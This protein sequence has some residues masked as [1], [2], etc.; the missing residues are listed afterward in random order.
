M[1]L[2]CGHGNIAAQNPTLRPYFQSA[3]MFTKLSAGPCALARRTLASATSTK[4][5]GSWSISSLR[6]PRGSLVSSNS[7]TTQRSSVQSR[8]TTT[9]SA[10]TDGDMASSPGARL[11][12]L[13]WDHTFVRELPAD[14][15]TR[16]TVRQVEGALFSR[17]SPTPPTGVPYLI[18]YSEKVA[19][20]IGLNPSECLRPEFPLLM[21]GAAPLPG[22][23]PYAACYGGHQFGSWAGQLGD[24]R[25][26]TLGELLNRH[27]P[28]D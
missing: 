24:G 6:G 18:A 19:R 11:E 8:S 5:L 28:P 16:N 25:A 3:Q 21:S 13:P 9:A 26:I 14:P 27:N 7:A 12:S 20:L 22:S 2:T 4:W 10:A 17:V 1:A 23:L 15:D